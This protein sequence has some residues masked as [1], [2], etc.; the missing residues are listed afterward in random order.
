MASLQIPSNGPNANKVDPGFDKNR[1]KKD[2][3]LTD[4]KKMANDF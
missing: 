1:N 2:D 4:A 3:L